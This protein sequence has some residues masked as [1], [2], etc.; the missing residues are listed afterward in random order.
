MDTLRSQDCTKFETILLRDKET[1]VLE[2]FVEIS[3]LKRRRLNF[4]PCTMET[5]LIPMLEVNLRRM[6]DIKLKNIQM[7]VPQ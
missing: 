6:H 4:P 3:T 7:E 5:T 2:P 1:E